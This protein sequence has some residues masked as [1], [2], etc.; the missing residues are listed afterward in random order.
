M[1][2]KIDKTGKCHDTRADTILTIIPA[3]G[4]PPQG[5]RI[6]GSSSD[7]TYVLIAYADITCHKRPRRARRT[8]RL[9]PS[10]AT[11]ANTQTQQNAPARPANPQINARRS[12]GGEQQTTQ[13]DNGAN[14]TSKQ[15]TKLTDPSS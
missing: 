15:T 10:A 8:H 1:P 9:T 12:D 6:T 2:T 3:T 4:P 5:L 13:D 11:G 7:D 14:Y